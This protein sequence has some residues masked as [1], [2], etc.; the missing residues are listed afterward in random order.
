MP[1]GLHCSY[2]W[3]INDGHGLHNLLLMRLRTGT[4]EVTDDR[5]HTGLVT[6]GG[7]EVDGLLGVILGEPIR[8]ESNLSVSWIQTRAD[9]V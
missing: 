7:G 3:C 1:S 8:M 5:G 6:H 4:V 2:R 9:K